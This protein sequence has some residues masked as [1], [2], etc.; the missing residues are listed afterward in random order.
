MCLAE[1]AVISNLK[2]NAS[3]ERS[4]DLPQVT[5]CGPGPVSLPGEFIVCG[6]LPGLLVGPVSAFAQAFTLPA[7]STPQ[8]A[9]SGAISKAIRAR[10]TPRTCLPSAKYSATW[11][12]NQT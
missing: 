3:T 10:S 11:A 8:W 4:V 12:G 9:R 5:S 2:P 6:Y 7:I 1:F